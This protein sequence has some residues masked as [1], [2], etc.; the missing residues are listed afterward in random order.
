MSK[1][2]IIN[3]NLPEEGSFLLRELLTTSIAY[4]IYYSDGSLE[5]C[6]NSINISPIDIKRGLIDTVE[7]TIKLLEEIPAERPFVGNDLRNVIPRAI[8]YLKSLVRRSDVGELRGAKE[9]LLTLL[10]LYKEYV[11]ITDEEKL[12]EE[13]RNDLK[14]MLNPNNKFA[15]LNIF[16][17]QYTEYL[18]SIAT[19]TKISKQFRVGLHTLVLGIVGTIL[20]L[21]SV[22]EN[23]IT[24]LLLIPECLEYS[25]VEV[26]KVESLKLVVEEHK[27]L[28][29]TLRNYIPE[30]VRLLYVALKHPTIAGVY[31]IFEI[32]SSK[33]FKTQRLELIRMSTLRIKETPIIAFVKTLY[34]KA[35]QDKA[36]AKNL[37]KKLI[38]MVEEISRAYAKGYTDSASKTILEILEKLYMAIE[39]YDNVILRERLLFEIARIGLLYATSSA[40]ECR[41]LG[42]LLLSPYDVS[43]IRNLL[44]EIYSIYE[45]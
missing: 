9:K 18:R 12:L 40:Q 6:N 11:G 44:N 28:R 16:K 2:T 37:L 41:K 25:R 34:D 43:L 39:Y 27:S 7:E 14:S 35:S 19:S 20:G 26:G 31:K 23:C 13:M 5:V 15:P 45:K 24:L 17:L 32:H 22:S 10:K 42:H 3:I 36:W 4:I 38:Q 21:C 30:T 8:D 1:S 33:S 29:N